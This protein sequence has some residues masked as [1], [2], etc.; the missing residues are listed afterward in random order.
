M[1]VG[2]DKNSQIAV[3]PV[4]AGSKGLPRKN[5]KLLN[6]IPLYL[7]AVLQGL[8]TVGRVVVTTDINEIEEKD[9]PRNCT[10][11]RR[12]ANL[13]TDETPM[14]AVIDHLIKD[15]SLQGSTLVLLQATTPLRSDSDIFD[16]MSL[17]SVGAYS[18]VFSVTERNRGVLKYGTLD[19]NDFSALRE[20]RFC[21]YN[22]QQLS[23][24]YGPNGAV[25]VFEANQFLAQNGFPIDHIGAIQM[26]LERS[27]D[28]DTEEDLLRIESIL[29]MPEYLDNN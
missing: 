26:P 2:P 1:I 29:G 28:V 5:L 8:R 18:L 4:R 7:R 27:V 13:A 25:H 16:A 17:F 11:C 9:L 3:V 21:F 10:L 12:P 14:A 20:D 19:K 15:Q 6:G 24:V 23:P 22:R